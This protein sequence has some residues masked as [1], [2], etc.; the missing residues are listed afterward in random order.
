MKKISIR[1]FITFLFLYLSF[2]GDAQ[3]REFFNI[4]KLKSQSRGVIL[5]DDEVA[6]YYFFSAIGKARKGYKTFIL[7]IL[8]ENLNEVKTTTFKETK[9][10]VLVKGRFN[11]E[12]IVLKFMDKW[13]YKSSYVF[14]NTKGEVLHRTE[15][16]FGT[17][18]IHAVNND[19]FVSYSNHPGMSYEVAYLSN[20]DSTGTFEGEKWKRDYFSSRKKHQ[21]AGYFLCTADDLIINL[22]SNKKGKKIHFDLQ[23]INYKNGKEVFNVPFLGNYNNQ[24]FKAYYNKKRNTIHV[25]GLFYSPE[26]KIIK[27]NGLG[28]FRYEL[29]TTGE[30][31]DKKH[32]FWTNEF[33][34]FM[35]ID[36]RGMVSSEDKKGFLYFHDIIQNEDGSI[37]AV[38]EQYR[39]VADGA[40][41]ALNTAGLL[42]GGGMGA[43]NTKI[44]VSDMVLFYFHPDFSVKDVQFLSKTKT[45]VNLPYEY[46]FTNVHLLSR[47]VKQIG[48]FDFLF[49]TQ[50]DYEGTT[51][52]TYLDYEKKPGQPKQWVFH[53][54]TLF[55][56]EFSKD[57]MVVGKPSDSKNLSVFP[58]KPGHIAVMEYNE[59]EEKL[60]IYL[61]K[62]NY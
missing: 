57:Q 32:L 5:E 26:V 59:E 8:D 35:K 3:S 18:E 46:D 33:R 28:L 15:N 27:D 47:Y 60:S 6:G 9:K 44:Q 31:I 29:S 51:S 39:K 49:T 13:T 24:P 22:A 62:I 36:N 55:D 48:G 37:L 10:T 21:P 16:D 45:S 30:I 17:G 12:N 42:L 2:D 20:V 52:I 43:S 23:A 50:N 19:G 40:G 54:V 61:E 11:G 4:V 1:V 7:T 56:D 34:E 25:L 38:A 53:A 41:I 14:L 58:A